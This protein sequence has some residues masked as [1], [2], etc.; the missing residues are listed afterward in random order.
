[1][2]RLKDKTQHQGLLEKVFFFWIDVCVS[3]KAN[4]DYI[5]MIMCFPNS[6]LL[7]GQKDHHDLKGKI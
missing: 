3:C 7:N 1:M 2:N 5:V 6:L 4:D